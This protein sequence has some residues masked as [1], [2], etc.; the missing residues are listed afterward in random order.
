MTHRPHVLISPGA[1]VHESVEIGPFS[2]VHSG[3]T[4]EQGVKIG[5]HAIIG[6][7]PSS[8]RNQTALQNHTGATVI[9]EHTI[10]GD[11]VT[12]Y[13]GVEV[14][15]HCYLADNCLIRENVHLAEDVVI[16][17]GAVISFNAWI[18]RG[19]KVMT[20]SNIAGNMRIGEG[21]FVGVHVTCVTDNKPF[22]MKDRSQH[23]GP[24]IGRKCF[25]GSNSTL[26]P[27]I[28]IADEVTLAAGSVA[29]KDLGSPGSTYIGVP[30]KKK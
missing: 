23:D 4:L 20:Q 26:L 1:Q 16:G 15:T 24:L 28:S 7:G 25:I 5:S 19:V 13:A 18:E 3:V 12:I 30:A 27:G 22:E 21:T 10:V 9:R 14:G 11:R 17:T 8:G 2:I 29:T 6:K